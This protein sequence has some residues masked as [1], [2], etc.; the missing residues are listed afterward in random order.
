[1][2]LHYHE[3]WSEIVNDFRNVET[4]LAERETVINIE[5]FNDCMTLDETRESA[6][7]FGTNRVVYS[8][9]FVLI[10]FY[11]DRIWFFSG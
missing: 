1:M 7:I 3:L 5:L 8:K 11:F 9:S 4:K 2:P 6:L 10:E